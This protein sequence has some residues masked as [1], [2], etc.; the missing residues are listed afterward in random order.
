MQ[1]T[2]ADMGEGI[3]AQYLKRVFE[4]FYQVD[5]VRSKTSSGLGLSI[6]K[7]IVE[8]HGGRIGRKARSK[9]TEPPL[10]SQFP[11]LTTP[12]VEKYENQNKK[13]RLLLWKQPGS[14]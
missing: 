9:A 6:C 10:C 11:C 7:H 3:P 4:R 14:F 12:Q 13:H 8:R 2:V 5:K 1:F